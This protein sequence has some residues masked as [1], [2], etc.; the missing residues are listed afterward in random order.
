MVQVSEHLAPGALPEHDCGAGHSIVDET[1]GHESASTAQV[2]TFC[3]SW[4]TVPAPVQ[5]DA[6]QV[7]AADPADVVQAWCGPHALV[8]THAVHP[9]ACFWQV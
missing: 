7:Q 1:K 8:V 2:A 9:L 6:V 5:M 3:P 4:H